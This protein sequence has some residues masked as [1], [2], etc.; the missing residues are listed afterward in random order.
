MTSS[1]SLY[2]TTT[3]QNSSSTNST[4]LYGEAG[5]PIP[6]SSGNVIVRGDLY[7]LSG[8]IL[9]T[10]A[11]GNIF[12]ANA[13][14]INLGLAATSM[15]IGA[16]SGTTTINNAL[17]ADSGDF[18]NITIAVADNQTI[19]TTSGELRLSSTSTAIKLPSVTSIYT[20]NTSTFNL[21][22]Q[23]TTVNAFTAATS[24]NIGAGTGT[25]NI[26]N[27]LTLDGTN[28]NIAQGT[29]F[30]YSEA[31]NRLNRPNFQSTT[32]NSSGVR[33]IG[34]NTSASSLATISA[35]SSSDLN[36]GSFI[37]IQARN[38][39]VT[40]PLR[41]Q[42]GLY[43]GG[44]IGA[45]G[46]SLA[47]I[48]NATT[49][50]TVN[51]SGPAIGTDLTT[52]TYVDA[53]VSGSG[54]TS[55][56]GTANQVIVSSSTGAVTLSLPQSIATTS[57]VTFAD[58]T[59]TD[60][61]TVQGNNVNLAQAT[62]IGYS[63]N[64]DRLN[65]PDVRST[66][67]NSSG[68]RVS[69]PNATTSASAVVSTFNT[70][71]PDNGKFI[72]INARGNVTTPLRIQTGEY[73][74]GTLGASGDSIVFVDGSSAA[75]ATINPAGPTNPTD[76][77]TKAY[78]DALPAGGVTSITGTANQVIASSS[79]GAIT[80]SLPQS[81]A[82]T[83]N[84]TFAGITLTTPL[85]VASG[86]TGRAVGNYSIYANEIH[87]GKDGNDTSGDGTLI[88]PVLTITKALTLIGAGR[89][90]VI[91]HPG[92]YSESPTVSSVNTTIATAE[93]TGAN[94]QIAGTLT[95]SAAARVSGIKLTNLTIT[96]SGNAYIS[97]CTVDTQVIKSGSNYVEII[98]SELQCTSGIQIT[99]TG[100]VSIVGNKCWAVT[101]SNAS[102]NVLIKDCYQ[103][104]TPTVTAGTLQIDGSVIFAASP[105][106]NAVTSSASSFI[107][108]A[109]SFIL[110]SAGSNVE[111]V[112]LSGFYSI[113]NLVYNKP[114]STLIAT[115]ATGGNLNAI[116]YFSVVNADTLAGTSGLTLLTVGSNG[117]ITLAPNGTGIVSLAKTNM[118]DGSRVLG[119]IIATPN[120]AYTPPMSAL[121]TV[122]DTNGIAVA[123]STGNNA[124]IA[125]RYSSGDTTAGVASSAALIMAGSSGTSTS[126]G[127]AALN[128]VMGTLNFDGYTAGTSNNFVSQIAT[129]NQGA[130]TT[131]I[132]PLQAQGY[133][134]QAFT[135]STTLTTAVTG[136]SGTGSVATLTF[137][138]QNTAP[139]V[140]GQSVTVAGMTP[141]GYNG[142]VVLTAA[143]TS[144]ISYANATTGFT[145]GGT[146]AA[147]NT[148]TAA[149]MG[150]RVRGYANSTNLTTANRFNF[151]DL[152]ASTANF[153]SA[154]YTFANDVIT[155]S[156]LTATNYMTLG[157]TTGSINQDTFT[158]KNT[159]GTTTYGSFGA[160]GVS[161]LNVDGVVTATRTSGAVAG[162][163]PV[164]FL[165]NTVTTTTAPATG[166]GAS[167]RQQ[168]AGSNG[169]PYNLTQVSGIYDAG[170]DTAI[171]FDVANGDQTAATMTVVRPF[172]TKPSA[173]I[174]KA[175]ASV[176]ATPGANTLTTV[177]TF[178]A[179]KF[180]SAVPIKFPTYTAAAAGAITGAVGWQISISNSPTVGGRMAFWDT[181]NARWSYISD[182][183]AV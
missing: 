117:N 130:G 146:I 37:N 153:K 40:N 66:T 14:T 21:L 33:A 58:I 129:M 160:T 98:N 27:D 57:N 113:L 31:N 137:T 6:D 101:V 114:N 105:S 10:A 46:T 8:N 12:P 70:N 47:F 61:L 132:G 84:P 62:V 140:V 49:Y 167:F 60:D 34:P 168:A 154:A 107:T 121:T 112:S 139:Y 131:A 169:T 80:L 125:V 85:P 155:G 171:T 11:T 172:E 173:T 83:S 94:T 159:A 179:A 5:T 104:I 16:G 174:I 145:S 81:I 102:A 38:G 134:R 162:T 50:A 18:G 182:N 28:F 149:G 115:S 72:N 24:L 55:L 178:D 54:V 4:S 89:N 23:P 108:L 2:G 73:V 79:T 157:A 48:D 29:T 175:T 44:T 156:T 82:T 152:T 92:T 128:Q 124:S 53:L 76:L 43:T 161:L 126:P 158:L 110:N 75:H 17:V 30:F 142:T 39:V 135:N 26:N 93:L 136:A 45:S 51:P 166:D 170:G 123:S 181:T 97:N 96:G 69:A 41:I 141:S 59:A 22:N 106:S 78:V 163:R 103:V 64:N 109:N 87:V 122:T 180:T 65:R 15:N 120:T 25:T 148:V 177:A 118:A 138:T 42:T 183:S 71:D 133:A 7:V 9:T 52:K 20:D 90:T 144:S 56:T 3:T 32:G 151:M 74:A 119:Q 165:R 19:T 127:G 100:T 63:E 164:M 36:N 68:F 147:A 176:S 67:G 1:S 88:N 35:F 95:L 77:T 13:T 91:V 116:D 86:G 150:F 143:T 111:R 99:G